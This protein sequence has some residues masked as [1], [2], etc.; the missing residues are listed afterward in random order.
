VP[1]NF[2]GDDL[3]DGALT[4]GELAERLPQ[5]RR[6]VERGG[7]IAAALDAGMELPD[8]GQVARLSRFVVVHVLSFPEP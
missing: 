3:E 6:E 1:D 2:A 4:V 5:V 8:A 7:E